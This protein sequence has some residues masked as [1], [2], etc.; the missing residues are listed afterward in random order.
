M[1]R[2]VNSYTRGMARWQ[3]DAGKRL[4][5]AALELFVEQ[6]FAETTVPQIT[7][8]AGLS[9]R[10]FFRHFADKREVL[11]ARE[12]E[13]PVLVEQMLA[14]APTTLSP[15][16]VI[17]SGLHA[18]AQAVF[19]GR[20][21]ELRMRRTVIQAD[22]G[23][24]ERELRKLDSLVATIRHGLLQRGG[25]PLSAALSAHIA[26]TAFSVGL[27]RW[28]DQGGEHERALAEII[29]ETLGALRTVAAEIPDSS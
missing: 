29:S 8:R 28:L 11:F 16:V 5:R 17:A 22:S 14:Q 20:L 12:D 10:T 26:V 4:E 3:A 24:R 27:T 9:T 1:T 2:R 15:M 6:G 19:E 13:V 18:F 7:A 23:L 25:D 21:E